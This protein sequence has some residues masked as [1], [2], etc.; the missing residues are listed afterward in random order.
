[1]RS[2]G[3]EF[4]LSGEVL[5]GWQVMGGYTNTRTSYLRDASAANIGLPLRSID[6]K[7][8]LRLFTS[9]RL[10][11]VLQGLT[12]GGGVNAYSDAYHT[13][14]GI[15]ARQAGYAVYNAMASYKVNETYSVQL[16]VNNL[17]DKVYFKKFAATGISNYYGD[18]RNVMLTLRAKF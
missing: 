8:T 18:P 17:F 3:F 7:H 14:S 15:T 13:A 2:E 1:M 11:G 10:G 16:N 4:D 9:Y 5:P 6:P 12:I